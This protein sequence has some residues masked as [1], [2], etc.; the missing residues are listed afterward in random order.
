MSSRSSVGSSKKRQRVSVAMLI[1]EY[2]VEEI[3]E[4]MFLVFTFRLLLMLPA[5]E[6]SKHIDVIIEDGS[7]VH[8][9]S[10]S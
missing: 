9:G 1:I 5:C 10:L 8:R 3:R 2:C 6:V 4:V 7:R